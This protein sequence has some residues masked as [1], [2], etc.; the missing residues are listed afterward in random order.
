M[1][2]ISIPTLVLLVG[3]MV[4]GIWW[5][6]SISAKVESMEKSM[7]QNQTAQATVDVKQDTESMRAEARILAQLERL[8]IKL[9]RIIEVYRK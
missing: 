8:N 7:I 9:D 5:A 2:E 6:A 1:K 3:Q 4:A